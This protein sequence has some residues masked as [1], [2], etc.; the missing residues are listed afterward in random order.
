MLDMVCTT[1]ILIL[2]GELTTA[3]EVTAP[4]TSP[5]ASHAPADRNAADLTADLTV[6]ICTYN[7]ATRLPE[8]LE[9]LRSC[10]DYTDRHNASLPEASTPLTWDILVVD[11]NS[12]DETIAIVEQFQPQW[13]A[14]VPLRWASETRQGAAYARHHGIEISASPLI[15]FLDDD[16][17]PAAN[18]VVAAHQFGQDHPEAGAYGS[19]IRGDFEVEPPAELRK[20]LPFLAIVERGNNPLRY[21][22]VKKVLPPSAGLVVRR[23][24]WLDHVPDRCI[25]GG[26][27]ADSMLTGEDTEALTHI[28]TSGWE[29]WYNPTMTI[30]HRIPKW[31]LERTYL[32]PFFR[33]IGLSRSVTRM[34]GLKSWQRPFMILLYMLNDL[35]KVLYYWLRYGQKTQ[36]DLV[37]SCEM[38]LFTSS[39]IS[40]FFIWKHKG[41]ELLRPRSGLT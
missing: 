13:P 30:Q 7:G 23:Q 25:L 19:Q 20:L 21:N 14:H 29:I 11:N 37:L 4:M 15:G 31:R 16:N 2:D 33:G 39:L 9:A 41:A 18:W 35:R 26:R 8:V 1:G 5:T 6:V 34:L 17:I 36:S 3:G 32:L 12:K 38:T 27:T 28:L 10:V 40:P 24:V 22:S